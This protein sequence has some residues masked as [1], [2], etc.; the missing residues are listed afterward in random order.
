MDTS[1]NP[2]ISAKAE[3]TEEKVDEPWEIPE[4]SCVSLD[5]FVTDNSESNEKV[6]EAEED[7]MCNPC[8]PGDTDCGEVTDKPKDVDV[9]ASVD[10]GNKPSDVDVCTIVD[11][12][13]KP[14]DVD[15][16]TSLDTG[17]SWNDR[18]EQQNEMDGLDL[19]MNMDT[20]QEVH[21]TVNA[22]S[23]ENCS[24]PVEMETEAHIDYPEK[25]IVPNEES[26]DEVGNVTL[27]SDLHNF[28]APKESIAYST[29]ISESK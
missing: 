26:N 19:E 20:R 23:S 24:D 29:M 17:N 9:G 5:A 10:T 6:D 18:T 13:N 15:V 25:S 16:G 8:G 7:S 2:G 11:T 22:F 14:S 1:E 3:R 28:T 21:E 4:S 12:G 27:E